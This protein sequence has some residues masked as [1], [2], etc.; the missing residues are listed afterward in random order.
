MAGRPP[1]WEAR[2]LKDA[3]RVD[4][5]CPSVWVSA[6]HE[7]VALGLPAMPV[8]APTGWVWAVWAPRARR[9]R[10]NGVSTRR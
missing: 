9:T 10:R 2:T 4:E 1:A 7:P 6:A 5:R 8:V 3:A